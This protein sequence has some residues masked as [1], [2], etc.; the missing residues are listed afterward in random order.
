MLCHAVAHGS[1]M[2]CLLPGRAQLIMSACT[3]F[4]LV[5]VTKPCGA[6]GQQV[7]QQRC[8]VASAVCVDTPA[9]F[10]VSLSGRLWEAV[11][12]LFGDLV[13]FCLYQVADVVASA[14][15]YLASL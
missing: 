11:S 8:K 9:N 4:R 10:P 14:P 3:P 13:L 6:A 15:S 12:M 1:F 5:P 7:L 2:S